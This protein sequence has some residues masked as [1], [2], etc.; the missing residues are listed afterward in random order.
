MNPWIQVPLADYEGHMSA[1]GVEQLAPLRELFAAALAHTQPESVAVLGVA[2]G[3]G[4]DVI[5]R[6]RTR[7]VV[8]IDIHP[9][10]LQATAARYAELP[11]LE[12]H[13]ADLAG[14]LPRI[15]PVEQV[16]VAL[17]F[18]HAGTGRCLQ[19]A[20][21][22]IAPGGWMSVVLQLPSS[23]EQGVSQTPFASLQTLKPN[24]R[25][26]EAAA[27]TRELALHGMRLDE[28]WRVDLPAGK[29]FWQGIFRQ[30]T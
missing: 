15:T 8:G 30:M 5:S 4:L 6:E 13:Q 1:D 28:E 18:E 12:L 11:G 29:A 25:F 23:S 24:F 2:G 22:L 10:Y 27:L 7:R 9:E 14:D 20:L 3:N 17:V 26:V 16:H 19:N 21:S